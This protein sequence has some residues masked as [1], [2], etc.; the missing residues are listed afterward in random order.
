[1]VLPTGIEGPRSDS[2]RSKSDIGAPLIGGL[3]W[4][5]TQRFCSSVATS[6]GIPFATVVPPLR[7]LAP[8][9]PP[10]LAPPTPPPVMP[11]V[12]VVVHDVVAIGYC[13]DTHD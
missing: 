6:Q 1:M 11:P 5:P 12:P 7:R 4:Q 10:P 2:R 13:V 9:M 3:V 8:P